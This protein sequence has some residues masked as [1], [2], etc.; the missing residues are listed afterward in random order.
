MSTTTDAERETTPRT[1]VDLHA[2]GVV[3]D[4]V[5]EP[6]WEFTF[7]GDTLREL[8]D[9]L[10]EENP[11]LAELLIAETDEEASTDGWAKAPE[12]LP[13]AWNKNPE[14]EN[15][16]PF[17]RV[18]VNGKFNENLDGFDTKIEDG[19]RVSLVKPFIFCC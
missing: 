10:F 12:K 19:D 8:L 5:D 6:K 11:D 1:T 9:A 17:A 16:R 13:G 3:R 2:T 15:T 7:E 18:L 14:G 4:A